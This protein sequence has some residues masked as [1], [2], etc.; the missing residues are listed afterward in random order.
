MLVP[1]IGHDFIMPSSDHDGESSI[2]ISSVK[3]KPNTTC[4]PWESL[5][6]AN[7]ALSFLLGPGYILST[8]VT[9]SGKTGL[10]RTWK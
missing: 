6:K 7:T 5:V 3:E 9:L 10:V 4:S 8:Y 2:L 1:T